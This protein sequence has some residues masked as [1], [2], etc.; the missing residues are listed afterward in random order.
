MSHEIEADFTTNSSNEE[1]QC[2]KCTSF[3]ERDGSGYCDELQI[4]V[5]LIGH[6]DFF[7]TND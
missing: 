2:H 3:V 1:K 4:E 5:P 7:Q 6:C